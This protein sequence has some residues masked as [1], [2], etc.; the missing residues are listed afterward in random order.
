MKSRKLLQWLFAALVCVIALPAAARAQSA[1]GGTVKD[2]SGAVLPGVTVEVA[3]E[4]LIEKT[5]TVSTDG[6]GQYKIVDLR[7]G[8]YVIT[9]SLQGFNTF[10]RDALELPSNFTATVNADLKVGALEESV[11]VS[12]ASPVVDVQS[13]QKTQV[14]SRDVLDAV[15]TGAIRVSAAGGRR[16]PA[17]S[18]TSA[19]ARYAL[20]LR[21][22]RRRRVRPSSPWTAATNGNMA[23][24]A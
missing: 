11:T 14:I 16:T 19:L 13:N 15:P 18:P 1:I 2:T 5:K 9:F 21:G 3:S 17:P 20:L 7:P 4:V 8:V 22:A 24:G 23:D 6:Q 10:K 12:G